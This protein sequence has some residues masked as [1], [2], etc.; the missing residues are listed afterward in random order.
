MIVAVIKDTL[1]ESINRRMGLVLIVFAVIVPIILI[2][3]IRVQHA[4]NGKLEVA[5]LSFHTLPPEIF[6]L[7][8]FGGLLGNA[9]GF[10]VILGV[11]AVA[12]LLMSFLEKGRA[13]LLIAK[14]TPRWQL[15]LG[16][17]LGAYALYVSTVFLL[18]VV[19]ALYLWAR[20]GVSIKQFLVAVCISMFTFSTV[21]AMMSV[22]AMV[23]SNVALPII[24]AFVYSLFAPG[25]WHR[26]AFFYQDIITWKWLQWVLD[27]LYRILPKTPELV[28]ASQKYLNAGVL[29][30]WWPIWSSALFVVGALGLCCWLMHRK[31][32]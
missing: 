24:L 32:F 29:D 26:E 5:M 16:H 31:S 8:T 18:A 17:Y 10:W 7:S 20:T 22:A 27:W 30:S 23:S 4:A 25:L 21:L 11:F 13:D 9:N 3:M 2:G 1:R 19:P 15:F 14:G 6:A 28:A 12:P